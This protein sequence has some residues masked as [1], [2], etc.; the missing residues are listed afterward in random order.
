MARYEYI[1][2]EPRFIVRE[3]RSLPAEPG[4]VVEVPDHWYMQTGEHGEE[5]L[6]KRL[7]A[8]KSTAKKEQK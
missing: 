2:E 6:F 1:G 4:G 8:T 3:G 7:D 5:P